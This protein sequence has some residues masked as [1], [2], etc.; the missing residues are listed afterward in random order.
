MANNDKS[1]APQGAGSDA[2]G[3]A[4]QRGQQKQPEQEGYDKK[5]DG[6]N[7]PAE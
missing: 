7:Q 2:A 3:A 6:P 4:S 1:R 5:L